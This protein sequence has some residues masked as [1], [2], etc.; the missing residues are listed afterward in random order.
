M[1]VSAISW[2]VLITHDC[3]IRGC[4]ETWVLQPRQRS[5]IGEFLGFELQIWNDTA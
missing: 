4:V 3:S 1:N 5:E 2:V